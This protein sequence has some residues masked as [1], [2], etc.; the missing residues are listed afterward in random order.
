MECLASGGRKFNVTMIGLSEAG[1]SFVKDG[2]SIFFP[3]QTL[4]MILGDHAFFALYLLN[5]NCVRDI[6][7]CAKDLVWSTIPNLP[8]G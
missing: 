8:T 2:L 1:W 3:S 4:F 7:I 5:A 6:L